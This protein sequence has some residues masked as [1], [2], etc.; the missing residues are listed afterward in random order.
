MVLDSD[1]PKRPQTNRGQVILL[2]AIILFG[3]IFGSVLLLNEAAYTS[4][5]RAEGLDTQHQPN[6]LISE[7]NAHATSLVTTANHRGDESIDDQFSQLDTLL[8]SAKASSRISYN[9]EKQATI[10]GTHLYNYNTERFSPGGSDRTV[11][12][13]SPDRGP[14]SGGIHIQTAPGQSD[15]TTTTDPITDDTLEIHTQDRIMHVYHPTDNTDKVAM[16]INS[17]T[18][19]NQTIRINR[20]E[21]TSLDLGAGTFGRAEIE[22]Y[23][24]TEVGTISIRNGNFG[25]GQI[26]LVIEGEFEGYHDV[27]N[28]KDGI[29]GITYDISIT[30]DKYNLSLTDIATHSGFKGDYT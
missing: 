25:S 15:L 24:N 22:D 17:S 14:I 27:A 11:V 23:D 16:F 28:S 21:Y 4:I 18:G 5:D 26:D 3:I 1:P 7:T 13:S 9:I 29:Y 8:S 6:H 10:E 19:E 12:S 2:M 20:T 30:T